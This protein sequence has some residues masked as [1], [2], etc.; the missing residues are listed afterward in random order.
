MQYDSEQQPRTKKETSDGNRIGFCCKI[1]VEL[2]TYKPSLSLPVAISSSLCEDAVHTGFGSTSIQ[3]HYSRQDCVVYRADH[4]CQYMDTYTAEVSIYSEHGNTRP[5]T[6]SITPHY[7][8]CRGIGLLRNR[9]C[10]QT[11]TWNS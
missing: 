6:L 3:L 7:R 4:R 8:Q 2:R 9:Q 11:P 5:R 1:F 10:T